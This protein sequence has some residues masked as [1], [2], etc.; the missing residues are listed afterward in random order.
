MKVLKMSEVPKKLH[1]TPFFTGTEVTDQTFFGD[2][3]DLRMGIVNFG[4][5]V[6]NKFHIHSGDQIL[7]VMEGRGIVATE[8]EQ[9]EVTAGDAILIPAGEKHWN[10]ATPD[11]AFSHITVQIATN[12]MTQL[13]P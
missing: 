12:R 7:I 8:T 4:R 10:G 1:A 11:S 5:G 6:R 3:K 9:R 2:S 13:E